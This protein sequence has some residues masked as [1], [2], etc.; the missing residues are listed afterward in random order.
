MTNARFLL[1]TC[2]RYRTID[3][4]LRSAW[5]TGE[6][7]ACLRAASRIASG[8][9]TSPGPRLPMAAA[10]RSHAGDPGMLRASG[11]VARSWQVLPGRPR[12]FLDKAVP[13]EFVPPGPGRLR[14][15]CSCTRR[16]ID[17]YGWRA[18]S[19]RVR[20]KLRLH[21][22]PM[23]PPGTAPWTSQPGPARGHPR[24]RLA[25]WR[26]RRATTGHAARQAPAA[27]RADAVS[28]APWYPAPPANPGRSSPE[29]QEPPAPRSLVEQPQRPGMHRRQIGQLR[30]PDLQPETCLLHDL[31][32]VGDGSDHHAQLRR[33]QARFRPYLLDGM[34]DQHAAVEEPVAA[35]R[36][37]DPSSRRIPVAFWRSVAALRAAVKKST[38]TRA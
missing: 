9:T 24:C 30:R 25:H 12:T 13:W 23:T 6:P 32:E 5:I 37:L 16:S 14:H 26:P 4:P 3:H 11:R 29:P 2:F 20:G 36:H 28:P 8:P 10:S 19:L 33:V 34:L 27:A 31:D 1:P 35:H 22:P 18:G 38:L 21:G 15:G 17:G 7:R